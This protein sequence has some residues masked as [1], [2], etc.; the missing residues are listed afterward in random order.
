MWAY[1]REP[2]A[3]LRNETILKAKEN[4]KQIGF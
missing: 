2:G 4:L 3:I 1:I